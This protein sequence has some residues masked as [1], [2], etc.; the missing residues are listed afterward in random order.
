[1]TIRMTT[2]TAAARSN[3]YGE[4]TRMSSEGLGPEGSYFETREREHTRETERKWDGVFPIFITFLYLALGF[5]FR[6]WHPGWLL[7]LTIP[8][9]YMKPRNDVERWLNPVMITLLYLVL[10]FFFGLWH[11]G[12]L[13]FLL[14]PVGAVLSGECKKAGCEKK[15]EE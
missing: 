9:Y 13:I 6:L 10:G 3:G 1:M 7:F 15:P 2:P 8:L 5:V 12:W 4:E 11:P 14:I